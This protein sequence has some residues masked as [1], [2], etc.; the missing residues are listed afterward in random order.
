MARFLL[1]NQDLLIRVGRGIST[2]PGDVSEDLLGLLREGEIRFLP[3]GWIWGEVVMT[4]RERIGRL[5]STEIIRWASRG[6]PPG[7]HALILPEDTY[8]L[9]QTVTEELDSTLTP[10]DLWAALER[11]MR[12][13]KRPLGSVII[14]DGGPRGVRYI[15][16]VI[17]FDFESEP[18]CRTAD[19]RTG[20]RNALNELVGRGCETIG[21]LPLGTIRGGI[22][23]E[24]FDE[25][26]H[27]VV[28]RLE[29]QSPRTLY[30]L[31]EGGARPG[32]G[33]N[34]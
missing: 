3:W 32:E 25:I 33:S 30:L 7:L 11:A 21:V 31:E 27:V 4:E 23:R 12:A 18:I 34:T 15:A 24:E 10:L 13:E 14:E 2:G 16:R 9:M 8:L 29:G 17:T 28:G 22:S 1:G 6:L 20:L 19:V 26:L 5:G